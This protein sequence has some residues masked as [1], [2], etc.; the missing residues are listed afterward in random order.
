M[1]PL[2]FGL[3]KESKINTRTEQII[4]YLK[5]NKSYINFCLRALYYY[6]IRIE[7]QNILVKRIMKKYY[8]HA[9]NIVKAKKTNS[10]ESW[11]GMNAEY[12]SL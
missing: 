12:Q 6:K 7:R 10:H 2:L 9:L 4:N 8:T 5:K 3:I 1:D 11:Y